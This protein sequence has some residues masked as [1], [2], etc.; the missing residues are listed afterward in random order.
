MQ[1]VYIYKLNYPRFT[2]SQATRGTLGT[3]LSVNVKSWRVGR[4][5]EKEKVSSNCFAICACG[6]VTVRY[7]TKANN[8]VSVSTLASQQ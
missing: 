3:H 8:R 6:C 5:G 2:Q 1:C 4:G 7:S